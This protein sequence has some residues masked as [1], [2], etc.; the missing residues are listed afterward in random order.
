M[1]NRGFAAVAWMRR[2]REIIDEEDEGLSWEEKHIKTRQLLEN[3]P[4]WLRLKDR[5][6]KPSGSLSVALQES[7]KKYGPNQA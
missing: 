6:V 2:R 5:I 4:L 7:R 1:R 3:D